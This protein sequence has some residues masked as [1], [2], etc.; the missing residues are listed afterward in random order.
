MDPQAC[1][2]RAEAHIN[3]AG[4]Q[5]DATESA[6]SLDEAAHALNDYATWRRNGG[7]E[8]DNGDTRAAALRERVRLARK[9]LRD[10]D[11]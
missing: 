1:L 7:F 8:P 9:A 2:D 5:V 3:D 6:E 11:W 4:A 10:G